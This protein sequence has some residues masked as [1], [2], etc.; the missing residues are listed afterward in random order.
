MA[1]LDDL[2]QATVALRLFKRHPDRSLP[3]P[4]G[5]FLRASP[6][7]NS[8]TLLRGRPE[9][10]SH[11]PES[12][13]AYHQMSLYAETD[14]DMPSSRSGSYSTMYRRTLPG[15]WDFRREI[16]PQNKFQLSTK[17]RVLGAV[18]VSFQTR[19]A[20]RQLIM[21]AV[22]RLIDFVAERCPE[23]QACIYFG[24]RNRSRDH[25]QHGEN[26]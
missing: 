5:R 23:T 2:S 21:R 20:S 8:L 18:A 13:V 3:A 19:G 25:C 15:R 4:S 11:L 16:D 22:R 10:Q 17:S 14:Y 1:W 12:A 9:D 24:G 26:C 7:S 6:P